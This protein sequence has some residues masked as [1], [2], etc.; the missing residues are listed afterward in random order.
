[1]S[2]IAE[3]APVSKPARWT[4]RVLSGLVIVFLLFDGAIKLV[5][6]PVVTETMDKIGYGS[7]ESLA[8][9]LGFITIACTVLYSIPPTSILGAILLTGYLGGAMASH[10]RI[11]S[12]LFTHTLFGLYLGLM[13]WGGLWF[14]DGSLRD[15]IPWRR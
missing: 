13:V 4:G 10:V 15:L 6:W 14:R 11:G 5:P 12:P 3:T 8:R 9:T 1:M 7:S 2:T